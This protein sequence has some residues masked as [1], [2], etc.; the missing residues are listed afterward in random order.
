M[1]NSLSLKFSQFLLFTFALIAAQA[2]LAEKIKGQNGLM[3]YSTRFEENTQPDFNSNQPAQLLGLNS[4]ADVK[5]LSTELD[6]LGSTIYRYTQTLMGYTVESSMLLVVVR[7]N[8]IQSITGNIILDL[9]QDIQSRNNATISAQQATQRAVQNTGAREFAW[10]S[11]VMEDN[12]RNQTGNITASYFPSPSLCWFNFGEQLDPT[13]LRLCYKV[14]VYATE[15]LSRAFYFVDAQSGKVLGSRTTLC[16]V[17][18]VGTAATAYSGSQ[19]IHS[20]NTGTS[21][22]LRDLTKGNGVITLTASG[23]DYTST[24]ANWTLTGTAQYALDAHYGVSQTYSFYQSNYNRNSVDNAGYALTSYVNETATTD[25]AYWDGTSMHYGNR[26]SNGAGITAID[27]TGH[28]LTH[29]VTQYTSNLNYSYQSGAMN[30]SMSDIFGKS[31]QFW[32]KPTDV[33]WLLSND[34][35]WNIRNM[36]NPNAYSQPDTYL[37][38][39]WATSASDNG[40]VHT[41]SGVGNYMFYLLVTGGSGV[42]DIGNSFTV[43]GIGLTKADAILYRSETVYLI[44]TSQYADWRTACINASTDLYGAASPETY[45]VMN[46]WFAVGIGAAAPSGTCAVPASLASSAI[47]DNTA[48]LTWGAASGA[49]SYIVQYKASSATTWSSASTTTNSLVLNSLIAGTAYSWQVQSVCTTGGNTAFSAASTFTT[50]GVAPIVYCTS[51]GSTLD[52]ITNVTFNTINNTTSATTVGYTDYTAISTAVSTGSSYT[53]TVKINTGGNYTNYSKAWIDWNHDGTFST[54]TEEYSLGTATNVTNGNTSLSPLSIAV[55]ATAYIGTTRMRVSTQY[56]TNPSPCAASFDGE[57]EDYS[58]VISQ[59]SSCI[60]PS[61]LAAT[62]ITGTGATLGWGTTGASSYTLQWKLSS[63]AAW[64]TV[65]GITTNSYFLSGLASCSNYSWQ[66][67]GNCGTTQSAYSAAAAFSTIGCTVVYCSSN[68]TN[69][70]RE[71]IKKVVLNTINNTSASNGGYGDYTSISTTLTG[72]TTYSANLTPGFVSTSRRE[73]WTIYIDYNKNGVFTDA[74]EK[75][76]TVSGTAAVT[77]SFTVPTAA[78]N[79]ATRMRIQMQYGSYVTSPCSVFTN[80]EVEDYTVTIAGNAQLGFTQE[81]AL[82]TDKALQPELNIYPNPTSGLLNIQ[83]DNAYEGPVFLQVFNEAGQLVMR[84]NSVAASGTNKW[85]IELE[86][87]PSGLFVFELQTSSSA[88]RKALLL[89][90]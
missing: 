7:N 62:Q 81:E 69:Q 1:R 83:F 3:R 47:G 45:A 29:G 41:N 65:T 33:N 40:G 51:S 42:N 17:D 15:P 27:V 14:D 76:V 2:Q 84:K 9:P 22:R 52:G 28:E 26:S 4:P 87:L 89:T 16:H 74:G 19:S 58:I 73:Y 56:N 68:G 82:S 72:G 60:T 18:A 12:L 31:V 11:Q 88:Y 67:S 57:V 5:L 79:G 30:E 23:A 90:K 21:Y 80:G 44:P 24:S 64:N 71:Y 85:Q 46:A 70:T 50:T 59:G 25:N 20:D 48:T 8:K 39:Y 32:S 78:L 35:G 61:A 49:G 34:M 6:A 10:Q 37:G 63:D 36:S 13:N 75:V 66:V 77:K 55:P 86:G 38:T 54:T 53:L 43:T